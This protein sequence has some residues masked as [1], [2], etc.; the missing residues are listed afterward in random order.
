MVVF[1]GVKKFGE[2]KDIIMIFFLGVNGS[3]I[4][5]FLAFGISFYM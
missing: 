3:N 2:C 1:E 5:T 4:C